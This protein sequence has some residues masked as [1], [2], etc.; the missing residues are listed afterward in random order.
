MFY[1]KFPVVLPCYTV[2]LLVPSG[3]GRPGAAKERPGGAGGGV[4]VWPGPARV[5]LGWAGLG[6]A[7]LAWAGLGWLGLAGAG[8]CWA[9]LAVCSK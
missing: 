4:L 3:P 6:W 5:G 9:G 8:L 2:F 7:G 1:R